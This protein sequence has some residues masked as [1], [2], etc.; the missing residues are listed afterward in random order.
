MF[1]YIGNNMALTTAPKDAT[2]RRQYYEKLVKGYR[3]I[4][5]LIAEEHNKTLD[6]EQVRACLD[7]IGQGGHACAGRWIQVI[8]E[9]VLGFSDAIKLRE[10]DTFFKDVEK[11]KLTASL[12]DI[13]YKARIMEGKSL[14]EKFVDTHYHDVNEGSRL[15]YII[16][17]QRYLNAIQNFNLPV[18]EEEDSYIGGNSRE[19]QSK[20]EDFLATTNL[21]NTV[22][23]RAN[24]LFKEE[25]KKGG[26]LYNQVVDWAEGFNA[27]HNL[28]PAE[29]K[30]EFM[31]EYVFNVESGIEIKDGALRVILKDKGFVD[32]KL[33]RFEVKED[34]KTTKFMISMADKNKWSEL[35]NTLRNLTDLSPK[36]SS[37]L[38]KRALIKECR[39]LELIQLI[40][41]KGA[42][43][44][45]E[46]AAISL[47]EAVRNGNSELAKL[48]INNDVNVN[49]KDIN[50][51]TPLMYSIRNRNKELQQLLLNKNADIN[52]KDN[53]N[54][55]VLMFA[56]LNDNFEL[57][58]Q[59][60]NKGADVNAKDNVGE[61]VLLHALRGGKEAIAKLL[62]DSGADV[63]AKTSYDCT[64]LMFVARQ[65]NHE[66][67]RLLIL[68]G[69][70]IEQS[71]IYSMKPND[72][73]DKNTQRRMFTFISQCEVA[74]KMHSRQLTEHKRERDESCC[75]M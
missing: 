31:S 41:N 49:S 44:T 9:M 1:C 18:I 27:K 71:K 52:A 56:T 5:N 43:V 65:N 53:R 37:E 11:D 24:A 19:I 40:I 69:A 58:Q 63:N 48:L 4:T 22:T 16:F 47:R 39:N 66:L 15:H 59:L 32:V 23:K 55:T 29:D 73:F 17:F 70:D 75:L 10:Q 8:E 30:S 13:F 14:A 45:A 21:S 6:A 35:L 74:V 57:A 72:S 3:Y 42:D 46:Y 61:T 36:T 26:H 54:N 7:T 33:E 28:F 64:A 25:I 67:A 50:D 12:K 68:K 62:I 38:L 34:D 60:I 20:A 51:L 2:K